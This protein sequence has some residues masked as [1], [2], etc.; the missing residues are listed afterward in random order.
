[1]QPKRQR[2][3]FVCVSIVFLCTSALLILN[4]FKENIIFFYT[5]SQIPDNEKIHASTVRIGGLVA[6][7]S[8]EHLPDNGVKFTITDEVK[9]L[10]VSYKGLLPSLFREGQGVVAEGRIN[11]D[12]MLIA[13]RILAKH[14]ETYMPKEV[15]DTLKR[16]GRWKDPLTKEA[17]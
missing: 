12:G 16:S 14:D 2:L 13:S 4:A 17:P 6:N 15:A 9:E 7:G 5:P 11:Q 8:L 1:M 3:V 10:E